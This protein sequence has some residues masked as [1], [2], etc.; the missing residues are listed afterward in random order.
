MQQYGITATQNVRNFKGYTFRLHSDTLP[1]QDLKTVY[2]FDNRLNTTTNPLEQYQELL[3]TAY[4]KEFGITF[5]CIQ[6]AD[7]AP[8]KPL[9]ILQGCNQKDFERGEPFLGR[10]DPYQK[11]YNTYPQIPKQTINV[12]TNKPKQFTPETV[13]QYLQY[14]LFTL[15]TQDEDEFAFNSRL[16]VCLNVV[17]GIKIIL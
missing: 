6:E 14:P 16:Q 10:D 7:F 1:V 15:K 5:E 4:Q 11:I 17:C 2:L 3:N 13:E 8:S 12:N 9:L